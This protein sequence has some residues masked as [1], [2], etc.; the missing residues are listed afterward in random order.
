MKTFTAF[1]LGLVLGAVATWIGVS[2]GF[3]QDLKE[4]TAQARDKI[5]EKAPEMKERVEKATD[6]VVE[7]ASDTR[8]TAT[9]KLKL[10]ADPDLAASQIHVS[11]TDALVTLSGRVKNAAQSEKAVAVAKSVEGVRDVKHTLQM[12]GGAN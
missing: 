1:L 10:A 5:A 8:I 6:A 11:T 2:P 4:S 9:V 7:A 12:A 3:R